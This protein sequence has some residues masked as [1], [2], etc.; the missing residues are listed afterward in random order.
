MNFEDGVNLMAKHIEATI[1]QMV[2]QRTTGCSVDCLRQCTPT[3]G[4]CVPASIFGRVFD[5]A[6]GK[7]KRPQTFRVYE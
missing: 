3:T 4:L 1:R 6:L 7:A 2:R 5:A